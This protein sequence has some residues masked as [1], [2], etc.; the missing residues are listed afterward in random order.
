MSTYLLTNR[1]PRRGSFTQQPTADGS[2]T[3]LRSEAPRARTLGQFERI[4][5]RAAIAGMLSEAKA[6]ATGAHSPMLV[7][8]IHGF[9][10]DVDSAL[11]SVADIG[12]GLQTHG[13]RPVM[14]CFSWPSDGQLWEY[15]SDQGDA[16]RSVP[17][18]MRL[19]AYLDRARDPRL[20]EVN[21]HVV[22]HSM[23][24]FL[25]REGLAAF[26]RRLG[27]PA[28]QP[29]LT[30]VAMV[31]ADVDADTLAQ[32]GSGFGITSLAR[33][34][35]AYYSRHDNTLSVSR[36]AKHWGS[37][38]LGRNGPADWSRLPPN[39]VAVDCTEVVKP[40]ASNVLQ[41][42]A[43]E[44]FKVHSSY[45]QNARW[46]RDLAQ[47]FTSVDRAVVDTRRSRPDVHA[48]SYALVP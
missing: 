37:A 34:V 24:N 33:R 39:V 40:I 42:T 38:R 35:T 19:L 12:D 36:Y 18:V 47:T 8:F 26:A 2:V 45:W 29:Y 17:A 25:L 44:L 22:A 4:T 48:A 27:Y 3:V 5:A 1:V 14:A 15:L 30:E 21:V 43:D 41:M 6:Q 23:G 32:G 46:L 10:N 11:A 31:A 9:N 28:K 13:L 20:C 7:V 16:Q